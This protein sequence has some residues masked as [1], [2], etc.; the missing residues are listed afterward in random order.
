[1]SGPFFVGKSFVL[2]CREIISK[3]IQFLRLSS[4]RLVLFYSVS[5][6]RI[7]VSIMWNDLSMVIPSYMKLF[8][9]NS[10]YFFSSYLIFCLQLQRVSFILSKT[11]SI[12]EIFIEYISFIVLF[13]KYTSSNVLKSMPLGVSSVST[14]IE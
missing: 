10:L 13:C 11:V 5:F 8:E 6:S 2:L 14:L 7:N 12:I 4:R 1:M 3:L 9:F